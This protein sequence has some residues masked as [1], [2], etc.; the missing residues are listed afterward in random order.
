ME[1]VDDALKNLPE[2][3]GCLPCVS[4]SVVLSICSCM[5]LWTSTVEQR[6]EV[7]MYV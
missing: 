7:P 5:F 4:L 1:A 2:Q 3:V 6:K